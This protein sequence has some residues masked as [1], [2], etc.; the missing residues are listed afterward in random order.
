VAQVSDDHSLLVTAVPNA[1]TLQAS[2]ET[3]R[4]T[5]FATSGSEFVRGGVAVACPVLS[6]EICLCSLTVASTRVRGTSAWQRL[7]KDTLRSARQ[8]LESL[9]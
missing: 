5:G 7:A 2:L 6:G 3:I 8:N 1:K 4:R 9:I